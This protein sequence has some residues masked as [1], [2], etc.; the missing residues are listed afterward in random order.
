VD[1]YRR[2]RELFTVG[3]DVFMLCFS[4]T[5]PPSLENAKKNWLA[6]TFPLIL[7]ISPDNT[8]TC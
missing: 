6:E 2:M 1:E 3:T 5:N 7:F 4:V 8:F